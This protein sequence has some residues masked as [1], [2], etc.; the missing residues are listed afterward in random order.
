MPTLQ[1]LDKMSI[2]INCGVYDCISAK[3]ASK[4]SDYLFLSGLSLAAAGYYE[5]DCGL[6]SFERIERVSTQLG[7]LNNIK[8]IIADID[9]SF[10]D[11]TLAGKYCKKLAKANV[12]GIVMEDQSRPRNV[13]INL[14]KF[15]PKSKYIQGLERIK[16]EA[17]NMFVVARTDAETNEDLEERIE[18]LQE[19]A[20][21]GLA[22]AIQ[23][24]GIR[25][26]EQ[27]FQLRQRFDKS[28]L[29]VANHV[30]GGKLMVNSFEELQKAGVNILTLSTCFNFT[31]YEPWRK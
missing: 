17:P 26:K 16:D 24:D 21:A 29:V 10:G 4:F 22:N 20:Q 8:P 27:I 13:G 30:D 28:I 25:S 6:H 12:Y 18:M 31:L 15:K 14:A 7:Y 2:Q 3:F 11:Y 19:A 1:H 23:I 9:D 5:I